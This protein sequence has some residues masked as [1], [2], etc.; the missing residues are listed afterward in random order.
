MYIKAG[1]LLELGLS[2][3]TIGSKVS[4]GEWE[5]RDSAPN[6]KGEEVEILL[7]SMPE[8][9]QAC[10]AKNNL[11][12]G[13]AEQIVSLLSDS[14]ERDL[15]E[16]AK[17]I[18][19]RLLH[20]PPRERTAWLAESLRMSKIV[21]QYG[22]IAP[23]RQ[24]DPTTG[25]LD[26]APGVYELCRATACVDY[27]VTSKHPHRSKALSPFTLDGL[28]RAYLREGLLTFLPKRNKKPPPKQDK[29]CA[30]ISEEAVRWINKNWGRHSGPYPCYDKLK[31]EAQKHGWK[32]PSESW[33]YRLWVTGIP[34]FIKALLLEGRGAYVAKYE[35]YVPRDYSDLEALQVLC[36]DH[37]ERDVIVSLA[38]GDL[39]RPWL[40]LWYDLRTG[41]I[42]GRHLSLI[43]SSQTAGM[44]YADG[45][46]NFGAQPIAR[47]EVGF[48]SY[49]YTDR[50]R[51]YKSHR[52]DGKVLSVHK[53]AMCLGGGIEWI[54][55]ERR[56]GILDE[57]QVKHLLSRG[58]NP[59]EKPVERIHKDISNW[60]ANNFEEY[61]GRDARSKPDRLLELYEEHKR[62]E[63]GA[64]PESPFIAFDSYRDRLDE[65]ITSYNLKGHERPTLGSR[66][67]IP[68]EEYRRLYTTRYDI[69]VET[70]T[71]LLLKSEQRVI[72]KNGVRCFQK[73]WFYLD[74]A[75]SEFKGSSVEVRYSDDD[76][77]KVFVF[78]PN[79]R[80][81]EAHRVTP[82]SLL[83]PDKE[84]VKRIG[85]AKRHE[86]QL[87]EEFHLLSQS[88][89]RGETA[90]DRVARETY[91]A[92]EVDN[93]EDSSRELERHAGRVHQLTRLERVR[94][95]S[96]AGA[97]VVTGDMVAQSAAD[98]S[99][100]T[101]IPERRIKEFDYD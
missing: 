84:T 32:I 45:V 4:S 38:N 48:Y 74:E 58:R 18:K 21:E 66:R 37:S 35:P 63:R 78:L 65:F 42:W 96:V 12:N 71:L 7:S 93:S 11:P 75:M 88:M 16:H 19:E 27:L 34:P 64:R 87:A 68:I 101:E 8:E 43:P 9:I 44:A 6:S 90:E 15:E 57:L 70:L 40:T 56:V 25:L 59:K 80:M 20:L 31:K 95:N 72:G 81:C 76:Y 23:K 97:P 2:T 61:C 50:G 24:R 73:H 92:R 67:V 77:S 30:T 98:V 22:R 26:F 46:R 99:I 62:F 91:A 33:F 14:S 85:K 3:K 89:L 82:T 13:Y 29:R 41:L 39:A 55:V 60:E 17:E 5:S 54:R 10:W 69:D 1:Q 47:P 28:Y 86:R 53:E 49:V 36:G 100:F 79:G 51:D 83:K 52:W 94:R